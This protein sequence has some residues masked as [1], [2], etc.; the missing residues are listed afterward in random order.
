[1]RKLKLFK[2]KKAV[3]TVI[4]TLLMINVAIVSGVLVYAWTQGILGEY[5]SGTTSYFHERGETLMVI[6]QITK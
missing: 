2:N 4:S 6:H 5:T 1:M 3:S